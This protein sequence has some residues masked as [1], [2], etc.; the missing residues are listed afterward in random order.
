L[1]ISHLTQSDYDKA[2]NLKQGQE[3]QDEQQDQQEPIEQNDQQD[4]K[5]KHKETS[6]KDLDIEIK[7]PVFSN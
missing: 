3:E 6:Y 1:Y 5:P 4:I 2:A 7:E